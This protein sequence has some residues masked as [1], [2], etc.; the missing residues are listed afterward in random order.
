MAHS[1]VRAVLALGVDTA[2]PKLLAA[3]A[4]HVNGSGG[5]PDELTDTDLAERFGWTLTELDEQD[6]QRVLTGLRLS[7]VRDALLRV[8]GYLESHGAVRPSE[9]DWRLYG[10]AQDALK[11]QSPDE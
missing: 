8:E 5:S 9:R 1:D 4:R 2:A 10:L 7:S 6:M 11:E 3:V